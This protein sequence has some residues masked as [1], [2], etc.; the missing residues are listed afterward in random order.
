MKNSIFCASASQYCRTELHVGALY[1]PLS[2][3]TSSRTD[4]RSAK[5][6]MRLGRSLS[7]QLRGGNAS[8]Q[9]S[10]LPL[11]TVTVRVR[12]AQPTP[13]RRP[14]RPAR[15]GGVFPVNFSRKISRELKSQVVLQRPG[16]VLGARARSSSGL[17]QAKVL[18][19]HPLPST[20]HG[21]PSR[22][23]SLGGAVPARSAS[24]ALKILG[25]N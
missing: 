6:C 23:V 10:P 17:R 13:P 14:L 12:R 15:G 16:T 25:V 4:G 19:S 8:S 24:L 1:P 2:Q 7:N 21:R 11:A 20:T 18:A 9:I 5:K 22:A 3:R